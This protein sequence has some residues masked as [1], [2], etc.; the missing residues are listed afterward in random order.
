MIFINFVVFG[1]FK[2]NLVKQFLGQDAEDNSYMGE[3][4]FI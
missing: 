1:K 4:L 2:L 3:A